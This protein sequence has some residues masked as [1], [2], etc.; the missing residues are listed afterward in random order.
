MKKG[1]RTVR[2]LCLPAKGGKLTITA[3]DID[4]GDLLS[5][6]K[7]EITDPIAPLLRPKIDNAQNNS[8]VKKQK[9]KQR[10]YA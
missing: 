7:I 4:G 1:L 5:E 8:I 3:P 9:K 10:N 2:D 6:Y